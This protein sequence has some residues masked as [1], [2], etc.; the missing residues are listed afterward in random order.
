[1]KQNITIEQLNELTDKGKER[2]RKWW[3]PEEGDLYINENSTPPYNEKI[4][5]CAEWDGDDCYHELFPKN[6]ENTFPLLSIGQLIEFLEEFRSKGYYF[7]I[8]NK[9][10]WEIS[11]NNKTY[12][13]SELVDAL[14]Q[15]VREILN[16]E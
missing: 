12:V 3:R 11:L 8:I 13:S 5:V 4:Q 2:L 14:W 7:E 6:K 10:I 15:S 16:K 9:D 1:M